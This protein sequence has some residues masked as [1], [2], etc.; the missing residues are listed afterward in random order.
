MEPS[1][2]EDRFR[3]VQ[4]KLDLETADTIMRTLDPVGACVVI[5]A[6]HG[7]MTVRGVQQPSTATTTIATGGVWDS[8]HADVQ[9]VM[10]QHAGVAG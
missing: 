2:P 3:E 9:F 7:C 4:E 8:G 1:G 10:R 5:T 6:E